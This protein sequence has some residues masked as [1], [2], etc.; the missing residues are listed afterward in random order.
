MSTLTAKLADM[1][2]LPSLEAF[3]KR[4]KAGEAAGRVDAHR[5]RSRDAGFGVPEAGAGTRLQL[6]ARVGRRRSLARA[7][8]GHRARAGSGVARQRR[9]GGDQPLSAQEAEEVRARGK[10][11]ARLAPEPHRGFEAGASARAAAHGRR[12]VRLYRLRYRAA[13]REAAQSERGR[14]RRSRQRADAADGRGD[15][16]FRQRRDQPRHAGASW[17]QGRRAEGL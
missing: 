16:R 14:A 1:Q 11:D 15:F 13:H 5:R 6:P 17:S 12:R 2:M 4:Y 10:A 9:Y 7:L 3:T 8:L